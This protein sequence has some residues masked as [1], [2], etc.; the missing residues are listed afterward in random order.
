MNC[1]SR[2]NPWQWVSLTTA[3]ETIQLDEPVKYRVT[4]NTDASLAVTADCNTASGSYQ[5]ESGKLT[6]EIASQT[7]AA[8][9]PGS[10]SD[11]FIS[12][13]AAA[14][15]TA[16]PLGRLHI[17]LAADGGTLALVPAESALTSTL[18]ATTTAAIKAMPFDLGQS[19]ITQ[20]WVSSESCAICPLNSTD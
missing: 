11:Q 19:V 6:I 9:P 2:A 15:G 16:L 4:F 7:R 17:E 3:Q 13:W 14:Y 8:C 18:P 20:T 12:C 1:A 5:G 10:R